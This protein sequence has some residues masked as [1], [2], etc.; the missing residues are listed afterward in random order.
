MLSLLDAH[1]QDYVEV[2]KL[3]YTD[4]LIL[5]PNSSNLSAASLFFF[6]VLKHVKHT[7]V[8]NPQTNSLQPLISQSLFLLSFIHRSS[9]L[10]LLQPFLNI[11]DSTQQ[12]TTHSGFSKKGGEQS[13]QTESRQR[14]NT[15]EDEHIDI[16]G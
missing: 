2:Y 8:T 13:K 3:K 4:K 12:E 9:H 7:I 5:N 10:K 16:Y 1:T 11:K 14:V 15:N 6:S